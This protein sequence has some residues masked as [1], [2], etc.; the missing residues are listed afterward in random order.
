MT[1]QD[2]HFNRGHASCAGAPFT[3]G[4]HT[5]Q[6]WH[7]HIRKFSLVKSRHGIMR[8]QRR[9]NQAKTSS[10]WKDAAQLLSSGKRCVWC[11]LYKY[12]YHVLNGFLIKKKKKILTVKF[13]GKN[14]F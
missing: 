4:R 7:D 14:V 1:S 3:F 13:V 2:A 5:L 8:V 6:G 10:R 9:R 11:P 12:I